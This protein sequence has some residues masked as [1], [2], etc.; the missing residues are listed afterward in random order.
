MTAIMS[1]INWL[2]RS[3][4][5]Q[6]VL[7]AAVAAGALKARDH[8]KRREGQD[9]AEQDQLESDSREAADIQRRV[10]AAERMPVDENDDRGYRD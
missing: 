9:E 4:P 8:L 7:A 5:A 1:V 6:W 3:R 10:A 2:L